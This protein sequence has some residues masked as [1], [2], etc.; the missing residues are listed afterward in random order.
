MTKTGL[1][2]GLS[3]FALLAAA[4]TDAFAQSA[5]RADAMEV[6]QQCIAQ[7]QARFPNTGTNTNNSNRQREMA[8][9]A[10]VNKQGVRP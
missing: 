2:F 9:A 3:A 1:F 6:R 5:T 10:C 4:S 8:Y 7:T